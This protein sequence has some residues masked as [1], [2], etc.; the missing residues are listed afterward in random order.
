LLC[1]RMRPPRAKRR[2]WILA[3][4][5]VAAVAAVASSTGP[6]GFVDD[7]WLAVNVWFLGY[8]PEPVTML[9][10][11]PAN[12]GGDAVVQD[13]A[14]K[15]PQGAESLLR[16][17]VRAASL[18][19]ASSISWA[20]LALRGFIGSI[21]IGLVAGLLRS[22]SPLKSVIPL[23]TAVFFAV[24]LD[25]R[26]ASC[27]VICCAS[28]AV[29]DGVWPLY[30]AVMSEAVQEGDKHRFMLLIA[31]AVL[32]NL[33]LAAIRSLANFSALRLAISWRQ[34]LTMSMHKKYLS[35]DQ[36][37]YQLCS[38]RAL[39]NP[40]QRIACDV[41]MLVGSVVDYLCG[42][43]ENSGKGIVGWLFLFG[44]SSCVAW[45]RT[46]TAT[47]GSTPGY[48]GPSLSLV[49]FLLTFGPNYHFATRLTR[50]QEEHQRREGD[51]RYAHTRIRTFAESVAFYG[52]EGTELASLNQVFSKLW[53]TQIA[54]STRRLPVDFAQTS[55]W[56]GCHIISC[57]ISG[58]LAVASPADVDTPMLRTTT[59]LVLQSSLYRCMYSLQGISEQTVC[60]A[61][62][63]AYHRRVYELVRAMEDAGER[64]LLASPSCCSTCGGRFP[65]SASMTGRAAA[66]WSAKGPLYWCPQGHTKRSSAAS[67]CG[68]HD[69]RREATTARIEPG[70]E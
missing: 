51:F 38:R 42:G 11:E 18:R 33:V 45:H 62:I 39:D 12:A 48:L 41:G 52:G 16:G 5:L 26:F 32:W 70:I 50:T 22:R 66:G 20:R 55:F 31:G 68:Y 67:E 8:E 35:T 3:V 28:S 47:K 59:F 58:A 69:T 43:V 7:A 60:F 46:V 29:L 56:Y 49:T 2:V 15:T 10:S 17:G 36:I 44:T 61:K 24:P 30:F 14:E 13:A 53:R 40:D 63:G 6:L 37:H 4:A 19:P 65:C 27:A 9:V 25:L 57:V 34:S 54:F 23:D 21:A 1:F 64:Q